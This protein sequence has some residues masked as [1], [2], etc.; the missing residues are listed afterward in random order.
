MYHVGDFKLQIANMTLQ[1]SSGLEVLLHIFDMNWPNDF[2][3]TSEHLLSSDD[4]LFEKTFQYS[5]TTNRIEQ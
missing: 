3:E 5:F 1:I 2:L 4:E